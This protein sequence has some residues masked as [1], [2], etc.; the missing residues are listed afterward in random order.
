MAG[1]QIVA[2]EWLHKN[3]TK[4]ISCPYQRG[5]LMIS[6]SACSKRYRLGRKERYEDLL[7]GD[8]FNYTFKCGLSLC[9][10]CPIGKGL[11]PPHRMD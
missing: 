10:T 8:L 5:N 6:K 4:M 1:N 9:Q 11:A 2:K 3:R 7:K